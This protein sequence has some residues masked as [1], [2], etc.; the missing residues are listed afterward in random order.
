MDNKNR[1]IKKCTLILIIFFVVAVI[2]KV[3]GGNQLRYTFTREEQYQNNTLTSELKDG[4][5]LRQDFVTELDTLTTISL[6]FSKYENEIQGEIILELIDLDMGS[7]YENIAIPANSLP[8]NGW[9]DVTFAEELQNIKKRPL[10]LIVKGKGF[11]N[12]APA[13]YMRTGTVTGNRSLYVNGELISGELSLVLAGKHFFA[14]YQYYWYWVI[15]I[16]VIIFSYMAWTYGKLVQGKKTFV[17]II[18][19]LWK[20]YRF[21]IKQLVSRDFKTKYKRSVLGY[22]WSFLNPVMT[23]LVQYA[24]FS[25]LFRSDIKNFPVYLLSG[26]VF[27][28]FFTEAVGQGLN[29][30]VGNA[31][32]ITK[33]YIPKY[34]YPMTRV[35]SSSIN[36][37]ISLFPLLLLALFTGAPLNATLI[38][39]IV[40]V[41]SIL[42]FC[43]GM[44][45]I[46][47][48]AMVFFRDTQY[49][50]GIISLVWMYG[51]PLFYP[52]AILPENMKIILHINPL[53]HMIT[54]VRSILI[55]GLSPEPQVYIYSLGSALVFFILGVFIFRKHQ[56]KFALYI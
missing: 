36:L 20:R 53:Y 48:T 23:M 3:I 5:I 21:L 40:P 11:Q 55:D 17:I 45:L 39:L 44:A 35:F 16:A 18:Y 13:L 24:V 52:E 7:V 6:C 8:T 54:F 31:A 14:Y 33:V 41:I 37:V 12:T 32:L 46:L 25:T 10:S 28:S 19:G 49:L 47:S 30:I 4:V 43:M 1:Y 22:I 26:T 34:I 38:L 56:D 15:G 50:W 27:F 9:Y 51:T 2:L 42:V 29:S